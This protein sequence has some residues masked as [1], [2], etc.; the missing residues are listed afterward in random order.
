MKYGS[1]TQEQPGWQ[2]MWKQVTVLSLQA[3]PKRHMYPV[4]RTAPAYHVKVH[5]LHSLCSHAVHALTKYKDC[6]MRMRPYTY[7]ATMK[8]HACP[9]PFNSRTVVCVHCA[10]GRVDLPCL[11]HGHRLVHH[12]LSVVLVR[13]R[14]ADLRHW[15]NSKPSPHKRRA[16][17]AAA[18][19]PVQA[20]QG[21]TSAGCTAVQ[22]RASA[23]DAGSAGWSHPEAT[24]PNHIHLRVM[25]RRSQV[26][27]NM[28]SS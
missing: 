12:G 3:E 18:A 2:I 20:V 8:A 14:H 1:L 23:N 26:R 28:Q 21:W 4:V 9:R 16:V 19:A 17:K 24:E 6:C 10:P 25:E 5:P 11:R 13:C 7:N 22:H 15:H 27:C